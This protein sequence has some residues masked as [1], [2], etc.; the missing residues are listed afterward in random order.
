MWSG[1]ARSWWKGI[2]DGLRWLGIDWDEG[3]YFQSQRLDLHRAAAGRLAASG[4]AYFCDCPPEKYAGGD[5]VEETACLRGNS[6]R[7][8]RRARFLVRVVGFFDGVAARI[9]LRRAIAK[10]TPP[11]KRPAFPPPLGAD[12][13]VAI[14][15]YG[16]S[17]Q[18]IPNHRKPSRIPS[19]S[20]G[21]FRST[22]LSST[23]RIIVPPCRRAKNQ[24]NSA[25]R[26]P[27]TCKYPVGEGAN[28]TRTALE[29]VPNLSEVET[30]RFVRF[31][32]PRKNASY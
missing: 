23:R 1:I 15:K 32:R 5:A 27:P 9:F 31:S 30:I 4:A 12:R 28:R 8:P 18:S 10:N 29:G 26:A 6:Q 11:R 25:V 21:R 20:S 17:S 14:W 2:L 13:A 19:T 7:V 3:P 16:P 24:L 22:S